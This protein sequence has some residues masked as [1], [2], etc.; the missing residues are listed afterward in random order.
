MSAYQLIL[1]VTTHQALIQS[2]HYDSAHQVIGLIILAGLFVQLGL[3][4]VHHS[5]YVRT[6][7]PT[8]MGRIHFFLGPFVIILGLINGGVGFNFA[9]GL[10]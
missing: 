7:K 6:N 1:D 4:L 2:K 5:V 8:P 9:G 10:S 3:G